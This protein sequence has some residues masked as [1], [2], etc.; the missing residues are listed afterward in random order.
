M[1][2]DMC[3]DSHVTHFPI[4][5]SVN[6]ISAFFSSLVTSLA[7]SEGRKRLPT[8]WNVEPPA[9][10]IIQNTFDFLPNAKIALRESVGGYDENLNM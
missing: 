4:M 7:A 5:I 6:S 8:K 3:Y 10:F 2:R 9:S 1:S